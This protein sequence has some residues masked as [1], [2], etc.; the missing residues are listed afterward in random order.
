MRTANLF[1]WIPADDL[2]PPHGLDLSPNSRDYN[3]VVNLLEAFQKEGFDPAQPVLVGYPLNGRV[4]LLTGTHRRMAAFFHNNMLLPVRIIL[5]SDVEAAWGTD[6]FWKLI[7][8][9]PLVELIDALI[10]D[11]IAAPPSLEIRVNPLRDITWR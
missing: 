1:V 9:I 10:D 6:E 11:I 8:D 3:K 2:D 4:Q 5:R 7:R